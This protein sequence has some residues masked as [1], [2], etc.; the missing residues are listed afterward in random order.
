MLSAI[1]ALPEM[2]FRLRD[3]IFEG[4]GTILQEEQSIDDI[5]IAQDK[6]ALK[7]AILTALNDM[8]YEYETA[9]IKAA[10][11][12]TNHLSPTYLSPLSCVQ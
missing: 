12:R 2:F 8:E 9:Y 4:R 5:I 1:H 7:E 6:S 10:L 11:L 3:E